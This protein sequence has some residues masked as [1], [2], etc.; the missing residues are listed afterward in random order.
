MKEFEGYR[1]AIFNKLIEYRSAQ[2]YQHFDLLI[3][4]KY[5]YRLRQAAIHARPGNKQ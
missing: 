5:D 2:Q 4:K 1:Q 3:S